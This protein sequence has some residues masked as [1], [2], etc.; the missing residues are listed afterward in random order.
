MITITKSKNYRI[1]KK[2][3]SSKFIKNFQKEL[4]NLVN[5][6]IKKKNLNLD[7]HLSLDLKLLSLE[8]IN[9]GYISELY[10]DIKKFKVI[11]NFE[12]QVEIR[13]ILKSFFKK[14]FFSHTKAVRLDLSNNQNWNLDWHQENSYVGSKNKFIFLWFPL[15]NKNDS[16][17]GGLGIY[18]KFISKAYNFNI[19]KKNN[20]QIQK[21]PNFKLKKNYSKE[22]KLNMGD[23]LIFDK[24]LFH[25]SVVNNSYKS[26]LSCVMSF[27]EK[28]K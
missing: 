21:I 28:T 24:Y 17:T 11:K 15:L 8:E 7:K 18:D 9:H 6:K 25:K 12:R 20:S 3:I 14:K 19:K 23:L 1:I 16:N 27:Y 26:K 5:K 4:N 13:K 10:G 22:V 2:A